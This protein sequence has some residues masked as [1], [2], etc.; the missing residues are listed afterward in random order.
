VDGDRVRGRVVHRA[1]GATELE[2][3]ADQGDDRLRRDDARAPGLR[4]RL[5]V[6]RERD[7]LERVSRMV[8]P[9]WASTTVFANRSR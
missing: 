1:D 3:R 9:S 8:E 5:E 7:R 2:V 6:A 4:R